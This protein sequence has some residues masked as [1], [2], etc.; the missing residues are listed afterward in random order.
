MVSRLREIE[1]C[2]VAAVVVGNF[3]IGDGDFG[4][5]FAIQKFLNRQ[6]AAHV[7]LPVVHDHALFPQLPPKLLF[8]I[9]AFS[10]GEFIFDFPVGGLQAQLLGAF[11]KDF[12]V[13][14]LI[15]NIELQRQG[16]LFRRFLSLGVD[17]R[18]VILVHLVALDF[19]SVDCGPH[20]GSM[21]CLPHAAGPDRNCQGG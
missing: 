21:L 4:Q 1:L 13:D 3:L 5:H 17:A 20:V 14:Q 16:F 18:A 12:V 15:E 2:F 9:R 11:E 7:L 6:L 10:L 19:P 8:G